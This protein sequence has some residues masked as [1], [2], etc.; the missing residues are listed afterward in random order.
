MVLRCLA[1]KIIEATI[2]ATRLSAP[3]Y[4]KSTS[5]IRY[6]FSYTALVDK[7]ECF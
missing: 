6:L 2:S 3:F 7:V 5:P 4:A 1:T